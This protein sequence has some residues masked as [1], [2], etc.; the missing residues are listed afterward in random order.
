MK[1][2]DINKIKVISDTENKPTLERKLTDE[3]IT[4]LGP[5]SEVEPNAE[6]EGKEYIRFPDGNIQKVQGNSHKKGGVKMNIPDGTK[7]LSDKLKIPKKEVVRLNEEFNLKLTSKDTYATAQQKYDKSVGLTKLYDEQEQLFKELSKQQDKEL[8]EGTKRIND[9]YL[10]GKISQIENQKKEKESE[11]DMFF[12]KVFEVQESTKKNENKEGSFA[13]GGMSMQG[14]KALCEKHGISP[15]DGEKLLAGEIPR[16]DNGGEVGEL[17]KK[18]KTLEEVEQARIAGDITTEQANLL[19]VE[20]PKYLG[21]STSTTYNVD[22]GEGM[23]EGRA[24][25]DERI[26]QSANTTAYDN[27]NE[28]NIDEVI[29]ALYR[30]FPD[31]LEDEEVFGAKYKDGKVTYNKDLDFTQKLKQVEKF[32]RRADT[33]MKASADVILSHQEKFSKE[34][35]ES[36]RAFKEGQ[37]FIDESGNVRGYD[38]MLGNFTGTRYNLGIDVVTP[39]ERE[40]LNKLGVTTV[41]QLNKALKDDPSLISDGSK[42]RLSGVSSMMTEDSDFLINPYKESPKIEE[43]KNEGNKTEDDINSKLKGSLPPWYQFPDQRP[44]PPTPM[45]AHMLAEARLGR[46]DPIRIGI[47]PQIQQSGERLKFVS[48]QAKDLPDA[49]R[50]AVLANA[51]ASETKG[52]NSAIT[53]ANMWNA[54]Q[55]QQAKLFNIGQSDREQQMDNQYKLNFE[56]RQLRAKANTEEEYKRYFEELKR[57]RAD[58]FYKRQN[59]AMINELTPNYSLSPFGMSTQYDEDGYKVVSNNYR[60]LQRQGRIPNTGN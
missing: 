10:S 6:L 12:S 52:L 43:P 8:T 20:L 39:E 51:Q 28:S 36:A 47:E 3:V 42:E 45:D 37:T 53:Q 55:Q 4:S 9:D 34:Q 25:L 31:I 23:L 1:G 57:Q 59:L 41:N 2:F 11:R 22:T 44:L 13:L 58:D 17:L 15:E 33:R 16:Y 56:R 29:T 50:F 35:V 19:E 27:I 14:F 21:E 60:N 18:Y 38:Q 30:N 49:Q 32:Q 7:V 54:Q 24:T 40:N 26:H 48:E 46:I 5:N